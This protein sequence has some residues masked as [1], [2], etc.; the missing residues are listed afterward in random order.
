MLFGDCGAVGSSVCVPVSVLGG[1]LTCVHALSSKTKIRSRVGRIWRF[2]GKTFLCLFPILY[3]RLT[4]F[5]REKKEYLHFILVIWIFVS[6]YGE[7]HRM[8]AKRVFSLNS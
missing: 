4:V 2:I 7:G 6:K 3:M 5:A 8:I 1:V